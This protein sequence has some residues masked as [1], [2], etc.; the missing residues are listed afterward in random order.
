MAID[1]DSNNQESRGKHWMFTLNNPTPEEIAHIRNSTEFSWLMFQGE[2][3]ERG[4]PHLQGTCSFAKVKRFRQLKKILGPRASYE[5]RRG[6]VQEAATYC[7]KD[8]TFDESVHGK[9]ERGTRPNDQGARTDIQ[10]LSLRIVGG[11]TESELFNSFPAL[12]LRY[13]RGIRDAIRL[14]TASRNFKTEVFWFWGPTGTGKSKRAFEEAPGAYWKSGI[15]NWWDGYQSEE[16]VIID[17]YRTNMCPFNFLLRL[18]DR[19]PLLVPIKGGFV[20]FVAKK[21]YITTPLLPKDTWANRID[22][23]I[24]QLERR[25]EHVLH[26]HTLL[27]C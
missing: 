18:L 6:T 14:C 8:A 24:K 11:A 15:D 9:Y 17:D 1:D 19:Y 25:I 27:R 23:D 7:S 2:R 21:I 16:V 5:L 22:E 4:T 26:F 12:F 10:Q 13:P 3:G 20:Q